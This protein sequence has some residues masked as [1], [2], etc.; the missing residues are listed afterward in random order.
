MS[1]RPYWPA[2]PSLIAAR[3]NGQRTALRRRK[4]K[5]TGCG[6]CAAGWT[7]NAKP[8]RARCAR[9]AR[10]ENEIRDLIRGALPTMLAEMAEA[11]QRAKAIELAIDAMR[12]ATGNR[13]GFLPDR[14]RDEYYPGG[15]AAIRALAAEWSEAIKHL[16]DDPDAELPTLPSPQHDPLPFPDVRRRQRL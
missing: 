10:R 5:P 3:S 1:P 7:P 16:E 8:P 11:R 15:E 12:H 14:W 4:P 2:R 6:N 13:L 9:A